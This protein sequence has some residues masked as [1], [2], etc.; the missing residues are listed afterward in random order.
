MPKMQAIWKPNFREAGAEQLWNIL[1]QS[2]LY[3]T[4]NIAI[5]Y[6]MNTV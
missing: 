2:C 6:Q 5:Q 4:E 1:L 3:T